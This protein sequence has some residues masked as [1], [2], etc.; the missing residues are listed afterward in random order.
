MPLNG[1]TTII[2]SGTDKSG[3]LSAT[4]AGGGDDTQFGEA[5]QP[6]VDTKQIHVPPDTSPSGE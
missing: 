2:A 1:D 3:N 4:A 5:F 6:H